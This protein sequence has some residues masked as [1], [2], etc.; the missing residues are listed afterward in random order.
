MRK[1]MPWHE[2]LDEFVKV[3][4][5]IVMSSLKDV[6]ITLNRCYTCVARKGADV[7]VYAPQNCDY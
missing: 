3:L 6:D 7:I 5:P 1:R 4:W 2:N